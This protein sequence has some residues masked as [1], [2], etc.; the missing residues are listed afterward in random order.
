MRKRVS[1]HFIYTALFL[2][3]LIVAFSLIY[4]TAQVSTV[5][6]P[7]HSGIEVEVDVGNGDQSV[8]AIADDFETRIT[9]LENAGGGTTPPPTPGGSGTCTS[10]L[11][12]PLDPDTTGSAIEAFDIP[13][14]CIDKTC[15]LQ[16]EYYYEITS[17]ASQGPLELREIAFFEF[18]QS[19]NTLIGNT[20]QNFWY[21]IG[22][23]NSGN[24]G[25]NGNLNVEII[26]NVGNSNL[27]DHGV[28]ATSSNRIA[29]VASNSGTPIGDEEYELYHCS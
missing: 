10:L 16:I 7:G 20:G 8:Q 2:A 12:A 5:P 26:A 15:L 17:G 14:E 24:S 23:P 4:V 18:T 3:G 22:G 1:N 13:N 11:S 19:S 29:L 28:G 21:V 25:I 27:Q 9:S 6:N